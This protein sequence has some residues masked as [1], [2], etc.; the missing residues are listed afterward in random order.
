MYFIPPPQKK[1]HDHKRPQQ[2]RGGHAREQDNSVGRSDGLRGLRDWHI[3]GRK[4]PCNDEARLP[5]NR[6]RSDELPHRD[7]EHVHLTS[8]ERHEA[9]GAIVG[10]SYSSR[11]AAHRYNPL[12]FVGERPGPIQH[13]KDNIYLVVLLIGNEDFSGHSV[14]VHRTK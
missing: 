1:E 13:G 9:E 11:R 4:R 6:D 14:I 2:Q 5:S 8:A 7:I 3:L 10:N 12:R